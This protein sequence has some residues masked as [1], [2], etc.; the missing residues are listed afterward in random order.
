[1]AYLFPACE[2]ERAFSP[3]QDSLSFLLRF[4]ALEIHLELPVNL[5]T[6]AQK[7]Y[8]L[9]EKAYAGMGCSGGCSAKA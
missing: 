9:Q 3:L 4:N 2:L 7:D 6:E 5:K 8:L 1:L